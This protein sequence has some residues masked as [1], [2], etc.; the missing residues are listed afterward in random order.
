MSHPCFPF[1]PTVLSL[2]CVVALFAPVAGA[3][4]LS[5]AS[6][7]A[8]ASDTQRLACFDRL[9]ADSPVEDVPASTP[10]ASDEPEDPDRAAGG[11]AEAMGIAWELSPSTKRGTFMVRTYMPNFVLPAHQSSNINRQ[12]ASPTRGA[13]A[14]QANYKQFEAKYQISLR[15][16]VVEGLVLPHADLWFAYTQ[17]SLWQLWNHKDSAPFRSTDYQ[18]EVIY[19]VP[20][21]KR[22]GTLPSGWRWQMAQFGFTHQSNGQSAPLSRSWNRVFVGLGLERGEFG[23]QIRANQRLKESAS[24]DDNP[25]MTRY[26]G[27]TDVVAMWL[28]GRA[29]ATLTWRANFHHPEMGSK[30]LDWTY[31]VHQDQPQGLRWYVQV[32]SGYGETLLDYN[33]KQSSVGLGVTLFHF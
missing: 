10:S 7:K 23:L 27:M 14:D 15:A 6:C 18:P 19:V 17:Q 30:Q 3:Q 28:P 26:M 9:F 20:V 4:S 21:P 22:L 31:P 29:V 33:H 16:K 25:D 11:V 8:I 24:E 1:S 13:A 5:A 2:A 32:F 12:P